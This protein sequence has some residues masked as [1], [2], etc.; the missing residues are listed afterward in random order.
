MLG[1]HPCP[2]F[3]EYGAAEA[4]INHWVRVMAPLLKS[5]ENI[6][7]NAV[8]MGPVVTPVMP[9]LGMAFM[10]EDL[11]LPATILK[12][13]HRFIDDGARTGETVEAAHSGLFPYEAPEDQSGSKR[14]NML[15][16]EPWFA[17]M[18]GEASGLSDAMQEPPKGNAEGS[19]RIK[20][21]EVGM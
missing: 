15:V 7:I 2:S 10:P 21:F 13:Y 8:M 17:W 6:T 1:V 18:H 4:G 3:P 11:V 9:G 19:G 12:A 14:R 5:K 20:E 16:Y